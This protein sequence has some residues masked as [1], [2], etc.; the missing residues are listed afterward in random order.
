MLCLALDLL[1]LVPKPWPGRPFI[2]T[3]TPGDLQN[4]GRLINVSGSVSTLSYL[5]TQVTSYGGLCS[6][7]LIRLRALGLHVRSPP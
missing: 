7:A 1:F 4:P 2:Y 6:R 3:E 5:T